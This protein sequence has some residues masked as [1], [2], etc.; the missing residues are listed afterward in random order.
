M[1]SKR[2]LISIIQFFLFNVIIV[3]FISCSSGKSDYNLISK[4]E[5]KII[6]DFCKCTEPVQPLLS[7]ITT[8]LNDSANIAKFMNDTNYIKQMTDSLDILLKELSPCFTKAEYF[9]EKKDMSKEKEQQ[10]LQYFEQYYPKCLPLVMGVKK[11]DSIKV[12]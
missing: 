5:K 4:K 11:Q 9:F 6:E 8:G 3:Y 12:K 2:T 10:L 1:M 7:R